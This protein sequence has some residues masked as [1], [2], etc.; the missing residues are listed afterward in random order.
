MPPSTPC[1]SSMFL[2]TWYH[3]DKI[4]FPL[5]MTL[6]RIVHFKWINSLSRPSRSTVQRSLNEWNSTLR[7][8]TGW[9]LTLGREN[10]FQFPWNQGKYS[11]TSIGKT[12]FHIPF[13]QTPN[14]TLAIVHYSCLS[15]PLCKI[16]NKHN[17]I[18]NWVKDPVGAF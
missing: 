7:L 14:A 6:S 16:T 11:A 5:Q 8:A 12:F 17:T 2:R 3:L 4:Y 10:A 9:T 15:H 13:V 1:L 18:C